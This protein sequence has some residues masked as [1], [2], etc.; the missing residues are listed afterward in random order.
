[1]RTITLLLIFCFILLCAGCSRQKDSEEKV[2]VTAPAVRDGKA[3]SGGAVS[4]APVT[5]AGVMTGEVVKGKK[6]KNRKKEK[7]T[8]RIVTDPNGKKRKLKMGKVNIKNVGVKFCATSPP[9]VY[10]QV[11]GGH[12]YY[13]RSDGSG[14]YTIYRD[15]GEKVGKFSLKG[16]SVSC[17][18]KY[19]SEFYA[20]T[21]KQYIYM[22]KK[23][24]EEVEYPEFGYQYTIALVDL[25]KNKVMPLRDAGPIVDCN[26]FENSVVRYNLETGICAKS[27]IGDENTESPVPIP[28][29]TAE[30]YTPSFMDIKLIDGKWYYGTVA[31]NVVTLWS[32]D[33]TSWKKEKLFC[34]KFKED[35][36]A[37]DY[38]YAFMKM[39]D[40]YIYSIDYIIPLAGGRMTKLPGKVWRETICS[41]KKYIYYIDEEF[42][43]HRI[44]KE[45][46]KHTVFSG[47]KAVNVQCTENCVYATG[48]HKKYYGDYFDDEE[49]DEDIEGDYYEDYTEEADAND[50]DEYFDKE[51]LIDLWVTPGSWKIQRT[52]QKLSVKKLLSV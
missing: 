13:L 20:V 15:K 35:Y 7:K 31:D 26:F 41:N 36:E 40:D 45:T 9:S 37:W 50:E 47:I 51:D 24:W 16:E 14:N 8:V 43:I 28:S 1:M 34:Y 44:N 2:S 52:C 25:K 48:Y 17:L 12:Y 11:Y 29:S 39:D 49:D 27:R 22:K 21:Q 4:D 32:L 42:K 38:R 10:A 33:L 23:D 3:G 46:L 5:A 19:R 30:H 18:V 6:E